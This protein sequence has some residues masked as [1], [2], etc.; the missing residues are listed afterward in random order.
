MNHIPS[1]FSEKSEEF[2][3]K[4]YGCLRREIEI[5]QKDARSLEK[6]MAVAVG[7]IWTWLY[8]IN[9]DSWMWC[10]PCLL[11]TLGAI[12]AFGV[13]RTFGVFHA[14]ISNLER[15]FSKSGGPGGWEHFIEE[16]D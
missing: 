11:A 12:R 16:H 15:A 9:G 14:Y 4:E 7:A 10:I 3:L 1:I 8:S 2:H 5:A 6:Y 13:N